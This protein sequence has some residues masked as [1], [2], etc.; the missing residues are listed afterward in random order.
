MKKTA[1][2]ALLA[3]S[4]CSTNTIE[5][6]IPTQSG[7]S[8]QSARIAVDSCIAEADIGGDSAVIGGYATNILLFGPL[9]GAVGTAYVQDNLRIQGEFDQ[10]DR[11]MNDRGFERRDLDQGEL[12]WLNQSF[13]DERERRLNHL[14]GGGT[15]ETYGV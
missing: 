6:S 9:F 7:H 1:F 14:V 2:L 8:L 15:I 3:A 13:G 12:F 10:V 5:N 4:A 11:C